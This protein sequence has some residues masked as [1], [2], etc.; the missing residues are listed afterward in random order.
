[1][2]I[3]KQAGR[4]W[5]LVGKAEFAFGDLTDATAVEAVDLPYGAIVTGGMLVITTAFD[6]ATSDTIAV[7]VGSDT[8]LAAQ[9]VKTAAGSWPFTAGSGPTTAPDTVDVT[10]DGT[11][12]APSA[13]AGYLIVEY[14]IDDRATEVQ[15]V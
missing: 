2:A 10:W 4:Q 6:S 11:G 1:M 7:S 12:A 15:P 13:G 3:T 8:L 9:D 5:P 14:V